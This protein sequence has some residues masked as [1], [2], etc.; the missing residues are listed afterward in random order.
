MPSYPYVLALTNPG[1]ESGSGT[2][3][4]AISPFTATPTAG[5][6]VGGSAPHSGT[7]AFVAAATAGQCWWGQTV[8]IPSDA[9]ADAAAGALSVTASVYHIGFTGDTDSGSLWL[10][11]YDASNV[12]LCGA[13]PAQSDPSAWTQQTITMRV[14][15]SAA[16]IRL[17]IIGQRNSGTELSAYFDDFA[18]QLNLNSDPCDLLY[19]KLAFSEVGW[20][21]VTGTLGHH[22]ESVGFAID[23]GS[24]WASD[25][26]GHAYLDLDV[27]DL[28]QIAS[29]DDGLTSF[30][31]R[32]RHYNFSTLGDTGRLYIECRDIS[33]NLLGARIYS[34]GAEVNAPTLGLDCTFTAAVPVST[35]FLRLGIVGTRTNGTAL[36]SYFSR[37]SVFL[38]GVYDGFAS[39]GLSSGVAVTEVFITQG[40]IQVLTGIG[41]PIRITQG[42]IQVLAE[43]GVPIYITQAGLQVLADGV[44]CATIW[45]DCWRITRKDGVIF[46]FTSLDIDY[47]WGS[48]TYRSCGSMLP[49]ASQDAIAIGQV[50]NQE[51]V[52]IFDD[53]GITEADIYGGLFNDAFVEVWRIDT[54]GVE[55]PRRTAAG[56]TGNL[57]HKTGSFNMEVVGPGAR[58][59]QQAIVQPYG[60]GCSWIFGSEECGADRE[61]MKLSATVTSSLNRGV[62]TA[63][64]GGSSDDASSGEGDGG[65]QWANGLARWTSGKNA[66]LECEV[67]TA[68]FESGQISVELWEL[69]G[70]R[71][72]VGDTLELLP[73]CDL[74]FNGGCVVYGRRLNFGGFPGVPGQD[75]ISETPDSKVD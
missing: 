33:S 29:I 7:Y 64:Q 58:L 10:D 1:A 30:I 40:G 4:T 46:R 43:I 37:F 62:F 25:A 21:N 44:P 74:D 26:S 70:F 65:L 38:T 54:E 16:K 22:L 15:R 63:S 47:I 75:A 71:P 51:L 57:Q 67:K 52:G 61:S 24:F 8:D 59:D 18:L 55:T 48:D 72:E 19:S 35:R 23:T 66:G 27:T 6:S 45:A 2:G 3:W 39:S 42:G 53:A 50:S 60:P 41:V 73:G 17:S 20:T 13:A 28:D 9:L 31:V 34:D 11:I 69:A 68:V 56:W 32:A 5:T 49:S 12:W 14:P 36:D